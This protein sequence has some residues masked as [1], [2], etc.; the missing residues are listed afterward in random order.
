MCA[1][2]PGS[3]VTLAERYGKDK[4]RQRFR[5]RPADGAPMHRFVGEVGHLVSRTHVCSHCDST[6]P[7]HHG[8]AVAR[9]YDFP[10]EQAAA[11][12]VM[13]GQGV[14]YTEAA[15]RSRVTAHKTSKAVG[16]QLVA[17]WVEVLGPVVCE[18]WRPTAWPETVVLDSTNFIVT[19]S[20]TG[21]RSQAFAV[22][23]AYGYEQGQ[24]SGRLSALQA[25]HLRKEEQWKEVLRS[26]PGEPVLVIS[27]GAAEIHNAVAAVWPNAF[28]KRCEH[29][30]YENAKDWMKV[31]GQTRFGSP[32][33][34]LL[35]DAFKSPAQWR[36]FRSFAKDYINLDAWAES[37]DAT[38]L[39]QSSR[40]AK[41]PAHHSTGALDPRLAKVRATMKPRAY[42][43][44][45]AE[46]TNRML[47]LMRLRIN[48]EDNADRYATAIREH[49]DANGGRLISQGT[50]M[51]RRGHYSL[52]V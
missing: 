35:N 6:V 41:L 44:R 16:A 23:A 22:L 13:V 17:N 11:A 39:D 37:L 5:C 3:T 45:N 36:Q 48:L 50:V 1:K 47:E 12:L 15:Q 38:V 30:L 24:S 21:D 18:E 19:N 33:M 40:R 26:L 52:L 42:C 29:H 51:D 10:V 20:R 9:R 49:L 7:T 46:R 43:Y 14:S 32:G 25:K 28:V 2:H 4:S 8:P 31:Y 34:E 27:D